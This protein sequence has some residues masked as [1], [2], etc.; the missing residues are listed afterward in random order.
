MIGDLIWDSQLLLAGVFLIA[1]VSRI[2]ALGRR[3][4]MPATLTGIRLDGLP[5]KARVTFAILE[6]AGAVALVVPMNSWPP[7]LLAQLAAAALG[8]L[9]VAAIIHQARR[10]EFTAPSFALF[11]LALS[12]VVGRLP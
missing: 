11:L 8:L 4:S 2:L 12:V 10:R 7:Y 3:E 5:P 6:I 1:G 9:T